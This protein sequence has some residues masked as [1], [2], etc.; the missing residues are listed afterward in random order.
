M[1]G[2]AVPSAAATPVIE[3]RDL[4]NGDFF[5]RLKTGF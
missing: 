5:N 1:P 4:Q 2:T 3:S